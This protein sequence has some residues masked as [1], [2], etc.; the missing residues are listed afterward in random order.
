MAETADA[1]LFV[2]VT[3]NLFRRVSIEGSR[4]PQVPNVSTEAVVLS[5]QQALHKNSAQPKT[6]KWHRGDRIEG[7]VDSEH[8]RRSGV[9]LLLN[10]YSYYLITC[11]VTIR[12]L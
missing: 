7:L 5:S 2:I 8:I 11:T 3:K 9:E 10:L 6:A 1:P 12:L 4:R